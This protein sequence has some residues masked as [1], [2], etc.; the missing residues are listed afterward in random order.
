VGVEVFRGWVKEKEDLLDFVRLVHLRH[1]FD[2]HQ[3]EAFLF[4]VEERDGGDGWWRR[5]WICPP[6][7]SWGRSILYLLF[8]LFLLIR[9][10]CFY[11][12]DLVYYLPLFFFHFLSFVCVP[13]HLSRGY[14]LYLSF[15]RGFMSISRSYLTRWFRL[16]WSWSCP[17][18]LFILFPL[19]T[20]LDQ[21]R[22]F[23]PRR[24]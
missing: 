9:F 16:V 23:P 1:C 17:I 12:C 21:S 8:F 5:R 3:A 2:V 7:R 14:C 22:I 10:L 24:R 13:V 4:L 11:V 18:P 19:P 15:S 20:L 6:I